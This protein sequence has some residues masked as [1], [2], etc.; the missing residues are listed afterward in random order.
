MNGWKVFD[1]I[2]TIEPLY[3]FYHH[4][5]Y[6]EALVFIHNLSLKFN[7][8]AYSGGNVELFAFLVYEERDTAVANC[9]K[10]SEHYC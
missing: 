2:F 8:K 4:A 1:G 7:E 9:D 3:V 10:S 5:K 6:Q